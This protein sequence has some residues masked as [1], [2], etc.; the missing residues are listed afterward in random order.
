MKANTDT[1]SIVDLIENESYKNH[2]AYNLAKALLDIAV[3]A[4]SIKNTVSENISGDGKVFNENV[5]KWMTEI[6]NIA[7]NV[8]REE[9]LTK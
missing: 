3:Q 6:N 9:M 4:R 8:V 7:N 1:I 5:D 2:Q